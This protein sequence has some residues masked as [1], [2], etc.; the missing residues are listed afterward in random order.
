M[1]GYLKLEDGSQFGGTI[2][3]ADCEAVGEVTFCTAMTGYHDWL[4]DQKNTGKI[5]VLTHPCIINADALPKG[6]R[7]VI[8]GLVIKELCEI[9]L[10]WNTEKSLDDFLKQCGIAGLKDVDTRALVIKVRSK[11]MKGKVVISD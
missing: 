2:F 4:I 11:P 8:K 9:P 3:G 6:S 10:N 7:P 5:L 1:E